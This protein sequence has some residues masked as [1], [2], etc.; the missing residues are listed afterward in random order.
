MSQKYRQQIKMDKIEKTPQG[1]L[2]IPASLTRVGVFKYIRDGK[3]IRQLRHPDDVFRPESMATLASVPFT[4]EHPKKLVDQKSMKQVIAGWVGDSIQKNTIYLDGIIT[5]ADAAAIAD[6]EAGKKELSCGYQADIV[7][8]RGIFNGETYDE[9]QTNIVYNHVSLVKKGRAGQNVKLHLDSADEADL[10][11]DQISPEEEEMAKI[12][13]DG[14]EYE[15]TKDVADAFEAEQK[16][17]KESMD[18]M[19]AKLKDSVPK[20]DMEKAQAKCDALEDENKTLK[21]KMD[22]ANDETKKA[23]AQKAQNEAVKARVSLITKASKVVK[24]DVK[25]DEM[26]DLE[27]KKAVIAAKRPTLDMKEKSESYIEA[28]FDVVMDEAAND[29]VNQEKLNKKGTEIN[30]DSED[31]DKKPQTS[32]EARAK[33]IAD[34]Q[35]L[36]KTKP[37]V[38][39]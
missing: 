32:A 2:R 36:W 11:E 10:I 22:S 33:M 1:F 18:A 3:V 35:E 7:D 8:E 19:E 27:I 37:E 21:T 38:S 23:E 34:S 4:N 20:K 39:K 12:K 9:R 29:K 25:L 24:A 30:K 5:V 14:K 26:S 16:K 31:K 15:V 17:N 6:I 13:I 28:T